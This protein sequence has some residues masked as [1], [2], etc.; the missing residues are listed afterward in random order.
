M[1]I[2]FRL[3]FASTMTQ[4]NSE[5][6]ATTLQHHRDHFRLAHTP[7]PQQLDRAK[8][9][10]TPRGLGAVPRGPPL[11]SGACQARGRPAR[12][13]ASGRRKSDLCG[14][15][16]TVVGPW[17]GWRGGAAWWGGWRVVAW[18]GGWGWGWRATWLW[19]L[20]CWGWGGWSGAAAGARTREEP[21][22]AWPD[23]LLL[24]VVVGLWLFR[25]V[26]R[27]QEGL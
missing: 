3:R 23:G 9:P 8:T 19:L 16:A 5:S 21:G 17:L 15:W 6:V 18:R 13:D 7:P 12:R 2:R 20:G 11:G 27:P 4:K 26:G 1:F 10:P 22:G 14:Y 25:P 24:V